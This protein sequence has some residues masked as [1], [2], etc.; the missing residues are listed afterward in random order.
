MSN[1]ASVPSQP[2]SGIDR[3]GLIAA[4]GVAARINVQI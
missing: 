3:R 4:A 2:A 1:V